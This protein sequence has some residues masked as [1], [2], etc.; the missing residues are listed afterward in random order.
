MTEKKGYGENTSVL[1]QFFIIIMTTSKIDVNSFK[2][3]VLH[4]CDW[5]YEN[6]KRLQILAKC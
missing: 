2:L 6:F 1:L 3:K 4:Y 5:Y